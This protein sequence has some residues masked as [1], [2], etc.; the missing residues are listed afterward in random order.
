MTKC[1]NWT[2]TIFVA[3]LFSKD[4]KQVKNPRQCEVNKKAIIMIFVLSLASPNHQ[5]H[6]NPQDLMIS[7]MVV[8]QVSPTMM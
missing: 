2:K 7:M 1:Q 3:S 5:H 6:N 8:V 4:I